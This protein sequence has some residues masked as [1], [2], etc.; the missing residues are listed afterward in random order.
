MGLLSAKTSNQLIR[1]IKSDNAS[2]IAGWFLLPVGS[3]GLLADL[4]VYGGVNVAYGV[5]TAVALWLIVRAAGIWDVSDSREL[6]LRHASGKRHAHL[7][8]HKP[9][10]HLLN[11][12]QVQVILAAF[13]LF[14]VGFLTVG[15]NLLFV[16]SPSLLLVLINGLAIVVMLVTGKNRRGWFL[17]AT[18]TAAATLLT[19]ISFLQPAGAFTDERILSTYLAVAYLAVT[20]W[21]VAGWR[22]T[23]E[24]NL[25]GIT[26]IVTTALVYLALVGFLANYPL[27]QAFQI[28]FISLSGVS[29]AYAASAWIK[30][31]RQSFAKFFLAVAA[32]STMLWVYLYLDETAVVLTLVAGGLMSLMAGFL[33]GSYTARML[34]IAAVSLATLHFLFM[35]QGNIY[36]VFGPIWQH[37]SV[38]L[39]A[40]MLATLGTVHW[41]Y[42]LW[43]QNLKPRETLLQPIIRRSLATAAWG[44]ILILFVQEATGLTQTVLFAVWG[45][46]LYALSRM[47]HESAGVVAGA[48]AI[49]LASFQFL[50]VD[51][52]TLSTLEQAVGFVGF[53]ILTLACG[54]Y[55]SQHYTSH[56]KPHR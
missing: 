1:F 15:L 24:N 45:I 27:Y 3:L 34:G 9:K 28:A 54:I 10:V 43:Q 32:A 8:H 51:L 2:R 22:R 18:A 26:I 33:G 40:V 14:G 23:L 41:W 29:L 16:A 31:S 39:G 53:A 11:K 50:A 38:W 17:I 52:P 44:I 12:S 25:M 30:V 42:G 6:M 21:V 36:S 49:I 46:W 37:T 19:S 56:K 13:L 48:A 20:F 35:V 4:Q 55:A 47:H 7:V 5:I